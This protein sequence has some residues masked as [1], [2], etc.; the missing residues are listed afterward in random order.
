M[1]VAHV[2]DVYLP[3]TGGIESQIRGLTQAEQAAG[4]QVSIFTAT[5]ASRHQAVIPGEVDNGIP[6]HRLAIRLPGS[7]P[8]TPHVGARLARELQG[9][10]DVVHVHGG[11]VSP[12]AWPALRTVVK[13]GLPAVVTVH[14]V[15]ANWSKPIGATRNLAGWSRWPVVWTTVSEMAAESLQRALGPA[16]QVQILPN[17]IDIDTWRGEPSPDKNPQELVIVSVA[18]LALRKR[19]LALID[20]LTAARQQLPPEITL[21]AILVGDGPDRSKIERVLAERKMTWVELAGW[22]NSSQIRKIFSRSDAFINPTRLE[23]FGIAALEAR[24]FGLPVIALS[25]SGVTSFVQD[26]IEGLLADDD[27]GL[28]KAIVRLGTDPE[29]L[30][31]LGSHNRDTVPPFGWPD[32]IETA[33]N[34]YG[35]AQSRI[36]QGSA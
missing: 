18:R 26:G 15:W 35:Q 27:A 13:A 25:G 6:V 4:D 23:S 36:A 31:R 9:H 11:L 7:L 21:R 34:L 33:H 32:V 10:T 24:T 8:V 12:F 19:S 30:A 28:V 14:S 17:G 3:R 16:C 20:V 29:L 2:S 22:R 1:R 5:P